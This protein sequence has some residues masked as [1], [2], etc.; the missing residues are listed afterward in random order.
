MLVSVVVIVAALLAACGA[1]VEPADGGPGRVADARFDGD[2]RIES[3]SLD[4]R[5]IELVQGPRLTIETV[6]GGL[7]VEPG[8]N[9]YFGSFTL[10]EDGTASFTVAGGSTEP[11]AELERQEQAVLA[12]LREATSWSEIDGGFRFDGNAGHSLT[13]VR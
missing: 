10:A 11:C 4:G 5:A 7:T 13:I 12:A 6:F 2:F 8:C 1:D 3:V 9:T